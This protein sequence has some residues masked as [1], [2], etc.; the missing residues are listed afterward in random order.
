MTWH[1]WV[2]TFPIFNVALDKAMP[3]IIA[4][5]LQLKIQNLSMNIEDLSML[6]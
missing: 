4:L 1:Q 3:P 6:P 5:L 2:N